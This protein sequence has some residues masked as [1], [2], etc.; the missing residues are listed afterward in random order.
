MTLDVGKECD[1]DRQERVFLR[2]L[3]LLDQ[4][5]RGYK[6]RSEYNKGVQESA[7]TP[8]VDMTTG[9]PLTLRLRWHGV[10]YSSPV[11]YFVKEF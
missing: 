5:V 1:D 10:N 7:Q 3:N 9:V 4:F 8:I 6:I 11:I 2:S